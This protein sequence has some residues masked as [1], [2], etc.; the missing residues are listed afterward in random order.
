LFEQSSFY[1]SRDDVNRV[2]ITITDSN[3]SIKVEKEENAA[4]AEGSSAGYTDKQA[5][6]SLS[7]G[8]LKEGDA[9]TGVTKEEHCVTD[10]AE[11]IEHKQLDC[12]QERERTFSEDLDQ[13]TGIKDISYK[14][15]NQF[16]G[17]YIL[18]Q[19]ERDLLLIDQHAA[20]ERIIYDKLKEELNQGIMSQEIIPMILELTSGTEVMI[21]E[22]RHFW[23][24]LGFKIEPFGNNSYILRSVPLVMKD[25]YNLNMVEDIIYSFPGERTNLEMAREEILKTMACKAAFKANQK[26]PREEMETLVKQL[27]NTK[28][29]YTCPHGRPTMIVITETELEK[30]F[31]RRL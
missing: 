14:I 13:G 17:T 1:I 15:M 29:S 19:R 22:N 28:G 3:N 31:K 10:P 9:T 25:A 8:F 16:L 7:D 2:K 11:Q 5:E 4:K 18:V 6:D 30:N 24:G 20:H 23:E 21:E 26:L 12:I 27:F